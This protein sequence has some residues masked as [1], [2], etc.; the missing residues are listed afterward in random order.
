MR[1]LLP[2]CTYPLVDWL[3]CRVSNTQHWSRV[4]K[5][6]VTGALV[7]GGCSWRRVSCGRQSDI[8][9]DLWRKIRAKQACGCGTVLSR[10]SALSGAVSRS[11]VLARHLTRHVH[12]LKTLSKVQK[13][14]CFYLLTFYLFNFFTFF[15]F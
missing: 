4:G 10:C 1:L 7:N 12:W 15:F 9:S 11:R 13:S 6:R 5:F 2:C 8:V 14:S 3:V